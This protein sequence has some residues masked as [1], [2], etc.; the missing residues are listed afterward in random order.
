LPSPAFARAGSRPLGRPLVAGNHG[1]ID[2]EGGRLHRPTASQIEDQ[3]GIGLGQT[4]Q[5]RRLGRHIGFAVLQQRQILGMELRK[6]IARGLRPHGSS[7]W[8]EGPR[9]IMSEPQGQRLVL[10]KLVEVFRPLAT[11]RPQ[12]QQAFHHL[13]GG[14][15]RLQFGRGC[16]SLAAHFKETRP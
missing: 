14:A 12:R 11:S 15:V 4:Q 1:G 13:R 16:A 6:K 2:V 9:Q 7:P 8:A 10:T 5:R 3:F